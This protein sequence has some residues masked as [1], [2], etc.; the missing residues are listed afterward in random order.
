MR[1]PP[2]FWHFK[3]SSTVALSGPVRS[4]REGPDC[5]LT[6]YALDIQLPAGRDR[7]VSTRS[8]LSQKLVDK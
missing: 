5:L 6:G 3:A 4:K 1:R 2:T 7:Q 8:C